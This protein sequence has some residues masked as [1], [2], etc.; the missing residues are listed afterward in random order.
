MDQ[1]KVC[2]QP[3]ADQ[4]SDLTCQV[5]HALQVRVG[6][7]Y[8]ECS[9]E[10]IV[11]KC[12]TAYSEEKVFAEIDRLSRKGDLRILYKQKGH[13]AVRLPKANH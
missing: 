4:K 3:H 13:Y 2:T 1:K 7:E 6:D 9:L 5:L 8:G 10:E 11:Q 12:G